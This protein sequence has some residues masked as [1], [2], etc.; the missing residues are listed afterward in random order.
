L[1]GFP[2][3]IPAIRVYGRCGNWGEVGLRGSGITRLSLDFD[4]LSLR[5]RPLHDPIILIDN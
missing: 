4:L 2:S 5:V 3:G 1:A